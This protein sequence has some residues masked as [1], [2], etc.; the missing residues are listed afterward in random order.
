[1]RYVMENV[2]AA[3]LPGEMT[4]RGIRPGQ[5][6]RVVVETLDDISL[7]GLAD[8]GGAFAFLAQEPEV[9]SEADIR[10]RNV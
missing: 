9:Y 3:Q 2:E 8:Q 6:L 7:A 4:R 5:R 1:M 10:Q